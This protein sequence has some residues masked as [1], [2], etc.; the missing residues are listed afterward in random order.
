MPSK[1]KISGWVRLTIS[2]SAIWLISI[3]AIAVHEWHHVELGSDGYFVR[4]VPRPD[5][6]DSNPNLEGWEADAIPMKLEVMKFRF[7]EFSILPIAG[8]WFVGC[9]GAWIVRG[10]KK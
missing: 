8:L 10:F 2:I 7:L 5:L 4:Y 3:A 1:G 9:L 6:K